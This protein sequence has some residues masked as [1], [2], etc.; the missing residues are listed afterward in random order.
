M[1]LREIRPD[2]PLRLAS[3]HVRGHQDETCDF[4]LLVRPAQLNVLADH[5][6][7]D[8]QLNVLADHLATDALSGSSCS[9]KKLLSSIRC[10]PAES[11]FVMAPRIS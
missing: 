11:I 8:A 5:L 1:T 2:L 7:T 9:C 3:L 6:D 4:D 10:P